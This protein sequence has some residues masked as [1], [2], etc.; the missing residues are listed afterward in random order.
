MNVWVVML[1]GSLDSIWS[2]EQKAKIQSEW[3]LR[4]E[5]DGGEIV[6]YKLNTRVNEEWDDE[7]QDEG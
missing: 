3:L 4:E 2:T 1:Y 6:E 7:T 5:G